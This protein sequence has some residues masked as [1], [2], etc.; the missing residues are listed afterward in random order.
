MRK[1]LPTLSRCPL[2]SK[3]FQDGSIFPAYRKLPSLSTH[4]LKNPF[5]LPIPTKPHGFFPSDGCSCKVCKE[6][7][8]RLSLFLPKY[9]RQ[10]FLS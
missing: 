7:A 2:A 1:F 8:K 4:L 9:F 6:A 3:V 5:S 10:E